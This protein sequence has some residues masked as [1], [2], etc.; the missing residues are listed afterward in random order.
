MRTYSDA[1]TYSSAVSYD[2]LHEGENKPVAPGVS[3]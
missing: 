1:I 2:G 3:I